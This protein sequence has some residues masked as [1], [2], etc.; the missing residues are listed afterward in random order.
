M[1]DRFYLNAR[2]PKGL[3]GCLILARMNRF[4]HASLAK[5]GLGYLLLQKDDVC[6]DV[7]CGGG[8]NIAR[9]LRLCPEGKVYG[10]DY[11]AVSVKKSGRVNKKAVK[12]G[13]CEIVRADV[14]TLPFA[15]ES[16]DVVTAFETIYFWKPI[17][18]AFA[19][20]YRVLKR[21]GKFFICNE[22]G[23]NSS[24]PSERAKL[25]D[26]TVYNKDELERLLRSVGFTVVHTYSRDDKGWLCSIAEK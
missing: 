19:Q 11:S 23:K 24:Q 17:E 2:K 9:L 16:M 15:E 6:L 21:G 26:M 13:R 3:G 22:S 1:F 4:E 18:S 25:L 5:W 7:G 12:E 20:I 8:A 10:L 14:N